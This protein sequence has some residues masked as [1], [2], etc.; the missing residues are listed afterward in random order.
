MG[1][2]NSI[3]HTGAKFMFGK[4]NSNVRIED[5]GYAQSKHL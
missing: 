2:N 3:V 5:R 1:I 4:K